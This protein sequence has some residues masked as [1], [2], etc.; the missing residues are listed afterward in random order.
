MKRE[1]LIKN[2]IGAVLIL[3]T[4]YFGVR[5]ILTRSHTRINSNEFD[6]ADNEYGTIVIGSEP[7][8]LAAALA[9]ARTGL[10]TLLVTEDESLGSYIKRCMISKMDPQQGLI[11]GKRTLLNQGI[12]QEIFG[13]FT[14]SFSGQ[15]YEI[16]IKKLVEKEKNLKIIYEGKVSEVKTEGK[17]IKS[18]SVEAPGEKHSY[19]GRVFIDATQNG[20]LL[21]LCGTPYFNGTEDLG[22]AG[23]YSPVEFNFKISGVDTEAL[24]KS[25]KVSNFIDEFQLVLLNYEKVNSRTKLLRPSFI[26]LNDSEIVFSGLQVFGVD[27]NDEEEL[28]L[29]YEDAEEEAIMLTAF[30]KN[31]LIAFKDCT[32]EE[33]PEGFFIPENRH[34]ESRYT[35]TVADIMENRDFPDKVALCSQEVDASKFVDKNIEYV[36]VK[37]NVYSIPLGSLIPVNLDNVLMLGSKA[38]FSSLAATSA[39]SIP[40][41][42]TVGE[43]AGLVAVYSNVRDLSPAGLLE[44]PK[45]DLKAMVSYI[46]RGGVML[47]DFEESILI[48]DT[49]EKLA[50]H[51]S[52]P[53]IKTLAE[54][55]LVSGGRENDFRLDFKASQELLVVLIKN[56]L[57]KIRHES[58]TV[59]INLALKPYEIQKELTGETAGAIVLETLSIPYK[60]GEALKTLKEKGLFPTG[61]ISRLEPDENV[62]MDTVYGLAVETVKYIK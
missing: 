59:D 12:Y 44:L 55:G 56:A 26:I 43:A 36:V 40:T 34:F 41:R 33:G 17:Y 22:I 35:L 8:G 20:D 51:W 60:Q 37:P 47:A 21:M 16:S 29:A 39:G 49:K 9:S 45:K 15:D 54:Y 25:K 62:T 42:I 52:Y 24:K 7:E 10:K 50:D 23:F 11:K 19:K 18:I 2:F 5:P 1:N 14:A 6:F 57:L 48:P 53:Y 4:L 61:I 30:L 38:G 28:R 46:K 32:Y 3:I 58:Y 31:T 13:K 27:V